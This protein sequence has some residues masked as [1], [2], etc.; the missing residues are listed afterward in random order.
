MSNSFCSQT[1]FTHKVIIPYLLE[2]TTTVFT[3][4]VTITKM[5]GQMSE[6]NKL[7]PK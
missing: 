6:E 5:N 1:K 3:R 2:G 7:M 4:E